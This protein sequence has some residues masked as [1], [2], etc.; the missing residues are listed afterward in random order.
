MIPSGEMQIN[1][2]TTTGKEFT[3]VVHQS[4]S[5]EKVKA[6]I[7][8]K[9][10][11]PPENQ[12]LVCA[13]MFLKD[14]RTLRDYHIRKGCTLNLVVRGGD[15]QTRRQIGI[16]TH[17][18]TFFVTAEQGESIE[19]VKRKI[20]D[21]EGIPSEQ[22]TLFFS[23][24]K[25]KNERTLKDYN[26]PINSFLF[27][28]YLDYI[29]VK[30]L[31][32]KTIRLVAEKNDSVENV[33]AKIQEKE[34][35]P[36]KYQRL[37][38]SGKQLEDGRTL[39]DYGIENGCSL[40]LVLRLDTE[41]V[42]I[43]LRTHR[44]IGIRTHERK[45]SI[46]VEHDDSIEYVKKKIQDQEGIPS[47]EQSLFFSE[48]ELKNEHTLKDYNIPINSFLF[49]KCLGYIFVQMLTG[50]KIRLEVESYDSIENMKT[51]IQEKEGIPLKQQRL[52]FVGRELDDDRTL[53]DYGIKNGCTLFLRLTLSIFVKTLT[54]E[55]IPVDFKDS[56]TIR[57]VRESV[58]DG[59]IPAL[60]FEG[61]LLDDDVTLF[62]Y[63][64][65]PGSTLHEVAMR[66]K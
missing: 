35:I 60:E 40:H 54:G 56:D 19:Y 41:L 12:R 17:E 21:Q 16:R 66:G 15:K 10:E 33:K 64:I 50:K 29:F 44:K 11:I 2:K 1:V 14:E 28:R 46:T 24:T 25:L 6:Q 34:G 22:Q 37:T 3:L 62:D 7:Q 20:Q 53:L 38:F 59:K 42:H 32:G 13:G 23:G 30:T 61:Q 45:F 52:I 9:E 65:R 26:I 27:L 4:D 55:K 18:R 63:D 48:M 39:F 36:L 51:K 43:P 47:E 8:N 57:M 5:I 49:L 31:T 58:K